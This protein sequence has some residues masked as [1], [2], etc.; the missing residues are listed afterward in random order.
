M[1]VTRFVLSLGLLIGLAIHPP[2]VLADHCGAGATI[3]PS[4]G[5]SG[6]TFVFETNLG[7]PSDI[8]L[9]RDGELVRSVFLDDDNFATYAIET[10]PSEAGSWLA[11]AEVRGQ[12]ECA[13]EATFTVIGTP[14]T[15]TASDQSPQGLPWVL[16][17]L[18]GAIA[19][20]VGF[21]RSAPASSGA[22][23]RTSKR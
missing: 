19:L 4:S 14:D 5:P 10:R 17:L 15:S 20:A 2:T 7:A 1:R 22:S 18:A 23:H 8:H 3:T 13:A 16:A 6:T 11:R 21:R 9:Y 12:T